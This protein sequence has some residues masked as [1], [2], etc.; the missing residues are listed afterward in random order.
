MEPRRFALVLAGLALAGFALR[1][2]YALV[3]NVPSGFGDDLWFHQVA[4]GLVDG[5]GFSDPFH[6]LVNGKIVFGNFGRPVATAFHPPLFPALLA[7]P[8]ALGI[9]SYTGH[10]VFG[11]ALGAA[12]IPVVGLLGRRVA[13]DRAGLAAAA[14]AAGFLPFVQREALLMSESL[15]G[16]LIALALLAALRFRERPTARRALA[17][18][19]VI[20]LASLT[21]GEAPLLV[22]LLALPI[23]LKAPAGRR[24]RTI[25]VVGAAV[26]A[27]CLPWAVRNKSEYGRLILT[28][29]DGSV[30]A[31][32][33]L[34][35]TYHGPNIGGY[36]FQGAYSTPAGR[37]ID[38]NEAVQNERWRDEGLEYARAHASR[39]PVVMVARALRT[40]ELFPVSPH[41]RARIGAV[42]K[43]IFALEYP[44]QAILLVT[45]LLAVA[46][47]VGMRRRRLVLWPFVVPIVMVTLVSVAGHG[48]TRYRHAGDV[49]LVVLAGAGASFAAA[50]V[51]AK[52]KRA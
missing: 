31:G 12:T 9:D 39:L 37:H 15:Y 27:I 3:A 42:N 33:N 23:A 19:V 5:R 18:G 48:D 22:L 17:L 40:W 29:G 49:A 30:F 51:A 35:S 46:G 36:S 34:P 11:C 13:G 2:A 25:L 1:V 43:R 47:A 44:E 26:V 16:L 41:A 14:I 8:S 7:I 6:S 38:P 52:K 21:R 50:T 32:S 45:I 10:Q 4:N 28:T 20:G 24:L